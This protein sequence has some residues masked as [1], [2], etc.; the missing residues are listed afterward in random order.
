MCVLHIDKWAAIKLLDWVHLECLVDRS[1]RS[2]VYCMQQ[3][4]HFSHIHIISIVIEILLWLL[5][6]AQRH[7]L[8]SIHKYA[9]EL[10]K[11]NT[12]H[13]VCVHFR[14]TEFSVILRQT[15]LSFFFSLSLSISL[16]L[17]LYT[18]YAEAMK[19][20]TKSHQFIQCC[21]WLINE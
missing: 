7:T 13:F 4:L 10:Q 1:V 12:I 20:G 19:D 15:Q 17:S 6:N 11:P 18:V 9:K 14:K 8:F 21:L 2:R 3:S 16:P 5:H